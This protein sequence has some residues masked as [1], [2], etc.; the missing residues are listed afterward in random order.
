MSDRNC[1]SVS[2]ISLIWLTILSLTAILTLSCHDDR[3]PGALLLA[4]DTSAAYILEQRS[5]IYEQTNAARLAVGEGLLQYDPAL[6][7]VAQAHA[8][9]MALRDY[10]S[11]TNPE[12][13]SPFDRLAEAGITYTSAGE[14]IAWYPGAESA[15]QGWLD[16][17][18]HYANIVRASFGKIGIGVYRAEE[19]GNFYYVQLFTN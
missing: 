19:Y 9:D 2:Y 10:F 16:S 8:Q 15:M 6:A 1:R 13:Q 12:G 7:A 5:I 14:N 11:H 4:D 17:P 3:G 18:G